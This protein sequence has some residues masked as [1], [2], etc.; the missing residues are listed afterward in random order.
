[1]NGVEGAVA[2][3]RRAVCTYFDVNY[4]SR[5]IVTIRGLLAHDPAD[6]V[7]VL[8]FDAATARVVESWFAGRVVAIPVEELH[9]AEPRL[10]PLRQTRTPWEFIA[11]HKAAFVLH[12]MATRGPFEWVS[13][14]DADTAAYASLSPVY[15]ELA[16]ASIGLSPHRFAS[17]PVTANRRYGLYNAGFICFRDDSAGR[18]CLRQWSEDC[19]AWCH[20]QSLADGR[21][22]NQG[23]LT[24][25]PRRYP[26]VAE[27][28]H[29][30]VNLAPWNLGSHRLAFAA[31]GVRVDDEPLLFFHFS[32]LARRPDGTWIAVHV[33]ELRP[34]ADVV[35][36]LY[37]PYL[38]EVTAVERELL[39]RHGLSGTGSVRVRDAR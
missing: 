18:D 20:E 19:I 37:R 16:A 21:F 6:V 32:S 22:M 7:H 15:A 5:G 27:I 1:M 39:A 8:C 13:F 30:G 24:S 33:Q 11:T 9:A 36:H 31:D 14:I 4:A 12:V 29:P 10:P 23:Y 3:G 26:R 2:P 38:A 28:R 35:A 17:D 34:R 25:W